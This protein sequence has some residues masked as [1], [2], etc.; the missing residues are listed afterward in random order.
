MPQPVNNN[1]EQT[2][3][4]DAT[5]FFANNHDIS[6][7]IHVAVQPTSRRIAVHFANNSILSASPE[8]FQVRMIRM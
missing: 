8:S 6:D 2:H 4:V 1:L 7:F 5:I 3:L